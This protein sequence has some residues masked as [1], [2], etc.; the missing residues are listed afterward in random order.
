MCKK[1]WILVHAQQCLLFHFMTREK[2]KRFH[3]SDWKLAGASAVSQTLS[4]GSSPLDVCHFC[5]A[6]KSVVL[7][8]KQR[9]MCTHGPVVNVVPASLSS[10]LLKNNH[11]TK[12]TKLSY[13]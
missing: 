9:M 4:L 6:I 5:P 7:S 1:K 8:I 2:A 13:R 10:A 12:L 3:T 11:N